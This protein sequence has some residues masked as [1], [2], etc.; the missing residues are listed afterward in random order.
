MKIATCG[1][2]GFLAAM[3]FPITWKTVTPP[4]FYSS[5]YSTVSFGCLPGAGETGIA[6][7]KIVCV[8]NGG[9]TEMT[10]RENIPALPALKVGSHTAIFDSTHFTD[11]A[12]ATFKFYAKA[13][14]GGVATGWQAGPTCS[15]TVINK[16]S[17]F[18]SNQ[19]GF[20]V[21]FPFTSNS[22][23]KLIATRANTEFESGNYANSM[24]KYDQEWINTTFY[25]STVPVN[26][27]IL[28]THGADNDPLMA[29][30]G[31]GSPL[32]IDP[33]S[34]HSTK[35]TG[36]D[37]P[38]INFFW[39]LACRQ[40]WFSDWMEAIYP[41]GANTCVLGYKPYVTIL[42]MADMPE[43]FWGYIVQGLTVGKAVS[44]M[45][46]PNQNGHNDNEFYVYDNGANG[47]GS[48]Q[49][50]PMSTTD[51]VIFGDRYTKLHGVYTGD[52]L[53]YPQWFRS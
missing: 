37:Q 27:V 3:A 24:I 34:M 5:T 33:I 8:E 46:D 36:T 48:G 23:G 15:A 31:Y 4:P 9:E 44:H 47:V 25:N 29:S 13:Y 32:D 26:V 38:P 28:A 18:A 51:A 49:R 1:V 35:A 17:I 10:A 19:D 30:S 42:A 43:I 40:G 11:G 7:M 52:D 16:S 2:M 20:D 53:V 22:L 41:G 14:S 21:N 50:R 12:T 39:M 6:A 45:I